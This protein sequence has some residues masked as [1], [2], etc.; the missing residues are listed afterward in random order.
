MLLVLVGQAQAGTVTVLFNQGTINE[1][2]QLTGYGTYGGMM[3]GM[4]VTA[5]FFDG[6]SES[7]VWTQ[8]GSYYSG[9]ASGTNWYLHQQ[10]DTWNQSWKLSNSSNKSIVQ[11]LIDAG[12]G[13]TV[14]DTCW[15]GSGCPST[16]TP[17]SAR[18]WNFQVTS[19]LGD[20]DIV[21]TYSDEVALTD[22]P[23]VGD[24]YR[25]LDIEF[26][27]PGG[28]G[29]GQTLYYRADSDNILFAGDIQPINDPPIAVC[30]DVT[31]AADGN[32][33]GTATVDDVDNGSYDPN[34]D[35]VITLS[36]SPA[37]PYPLGDTIV[38]LTVT[39]NG[40]LSDT[41][42]ATVTVIDDTPP[43]VM[44]CPGDRTIVADDNW[45]AIMPDLTSEVSATDNCDTITVT[46]DPVAGAAIDPGDTIVTITVTD[47]SGNTSTCATA[48]IITVIVP[49]DLD[50]KPGSC[51]NPINKTIDNKA[52]IP[53][54][55]LGTDLLDVNEIEIN[56]ISI[57]GSV[58]PVKVPSIEDVGTPY[59]G[60]ECGCHA[61]EGDGID[62]LVIHFSSR[63]VVLALGLTNMEFKAIVPI[64]VE[65]TLQSGVQFIATDC[66][67]I[68]PR[69]D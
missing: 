66:V 2:E 33:E 1:T 4:D 5:V 39:D 56:S 68:V 11:I 45:Q 14:F 3:D 63:D 41:C 60:D 61:L 29:S 48:P 52:R 21:A 26:T 36:L 49:V 22:S 55:L 18:G 46:Q 35:D 15:G 58:F 28:F 16:G 23:P 7:V 64:T 8:L 40:G 9:R 30:Q 67:K 62:D 65:G 42:T 54:A 53:M 32:C 38:E 6:T 31:V 50:I 27:N 20:L 12:P 69:M 59:E 13:D 47:G 51:P 19:G 34:V 57:A 10:G 37:G 17:G 25:W 43:A 24:L 44:A